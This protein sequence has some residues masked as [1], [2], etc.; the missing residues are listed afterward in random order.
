MFAAA[1]SV[2][3]ACTASRTKSQRILPV[4]P[5]GSAREME[6]SIMMYMST[7]TRLA[8]NLM[9]AQVAAASP[10]SAG[11]KGRP[12]HAAVGVP[13]G[14]LGPAPVAPVPLDG[15][16]ARPDDAVPPAPLEDAG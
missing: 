12:E 6:R 8:S 2:T 7:S 9:P 4:L 15:L 5:T 14:P 11:S 1:G 16:P 13:V 10:A 3:N